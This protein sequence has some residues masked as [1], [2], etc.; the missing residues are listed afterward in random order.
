L[1]V[2]IETFGGD[3]NKSDKTSECDSRQQ[4]QR[5][6]QFVH[7]H[8]SFRTFCLL[9][10]LEENCF[11]RFRPTDV[12]SSAAVYWNGWNKQP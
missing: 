2:T 4:A 11:E 9:E 5:H 10:S 8:V 6:S 3:T 7:T 12:T 1:S